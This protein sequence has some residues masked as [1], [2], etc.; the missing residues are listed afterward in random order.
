MKW[1]RKRNR[2]NPES[3][4]NLRPSEDLQ[5]IRKKFED[6]YALLEANNLL[7]HSI[8]DMEEKSQGEY[9][10]DLNYIRHKLGQ[11]RPL[12]VEIIERM[13]ALGG[14]SYE[15]LHTRYKLIDSQIDVVLPSNRPLRKDKYTRPFNRLERMH[16]YS[17]GSKNA[18]LGEMKSRLGLP[19]PP[20]FAIT[21]WAY[22]CF[23]E[24]N[25]LQQRV[26]RE[27]GLID[28]RSPEDL[29]RVSESIRELVRSSPVPDD[30]AAAIH[31]AADNL[32]T[33]AGSNR[34][35]MRSSAIGE[36]TL[37]S[38][39][40][41]YRSYLNVP[42]DKL[43][44][45]YREVLANKFTP[46]AIYYF[47]SHDLSEAELAMSVGCV[48][49]VDAAAAGVAYT[50]C[51]VNP[52]DD[53]VMI[54]SIFGLGKSLVDGTLAPDVFRV[55]REETQVIQETVS[56][57]PV[58]LV[59]NDRGG[60]VEEQVPEEERGQP[61]LSDEHIRQ[62]AEYAIKLESHYSS[63]QDIEWALDQSGQI[64]LLQTRPLQV[65]KAGQ[66]DPPP[67]IADQSRLA[68]QGIT[69]CHGAGS[70]KI[71][72]VAAA[73]DLP[74]VPEGAVLVAPHPFPGLITVM[75][76]I[77]ALV[78]AVGSVAS[79]MATIAREYRIPTLV[80]VP[81]ADKLPL[82]REVTVDATGAVIYDGH[83]DALI[84]ARRPQFAAADEGTIYD[85]LGRVL[86]LI[87]PLRLIYPDDDDFVIE[88]CVT[89]HDITRFAHQRAT[90]EMFLGA[91]NLEGKDLISLRLKTDIPLQVNI[92]YIDRDY[93]TTR[94]EG[95]I[96]PED[97]GS[98]PMEQFWAGVVAEGWPQTPTPRGMKP[99]GTIAGKESHPGA[100]LGYSENSFAILG[101]EYMIVSLRMGYHLATVEAIGSEDLSKNYIRM[102]FSYGGAALDRR[103][104][105]VK[106]ITSILSA[107]GFV[108]Q[109]RADFL[110]ATM[111]YKD[112]QHILHTLHLLGRL[113]ILTKQLDMALSSDGITQWYTRDFMKKLGL[114]AKEESSSGHDTGRVESN[115][116]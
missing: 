67:E 66:G 30:I 34:F 62:L 45:Y 103:A 113:T 78:T 107:M 25:D 2:T 85:V 61:S 29:A 97:I 53:R 8:G 84:A 31:E 69:V 99:V 70:G 94:N 108:C 4:P 96:A 44:E 48:S 105:R 42:T 26:S 81:G 74:A 15:G 13:V 110:S 37:F 80:G 27:L 24:A 59:M 100:R 79:H 38:F 17:V 36:D 16:S 1:F 83:Q 95:W 56:D 90:E 22:K 82:G 92:I 106:L 71:H 9:L 68:E 20:G 32:A 98:P 43:V 12:V 63:P 114:T 93:D 54:S 3:P 55:T 49:M 21:A 39:A 102:Q 57:K 104:R 88:N 72:H 111:S 116:N 65:V 51:P 76:K 91:K 47:L 41:Q 89:F 7:L 46:Q 115:G 52:A 64:Q 33:Y 75:G 73:A 101:Y 11:V 58:R 86:D 23:I 87:S 19:V 77:N 40:G 109:R 18:Q 6:F 60:T 10:F 112:S 35:S 50:R 14:E 5:V 28:I